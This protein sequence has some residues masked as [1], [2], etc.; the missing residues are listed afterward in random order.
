MRDDLTLDPWDIECGVLNL[1]VLAGNGTHWTCWYKVNNRCYYFDSFGLPPP[2]EFYEYIKC[3]VIHSTYQVQQMGEVICGQ[4]CLL[5]LYLVVV[6]EMAFHD[7][8]IHIA[9]GIR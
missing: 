3:D 1:D 6:C 4:L 7:S 5:L 8:L 9:N 2:N